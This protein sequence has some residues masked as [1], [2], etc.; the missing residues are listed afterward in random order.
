MGGEILVRRMTNAIRPG[1]AAS[2]LAKDDAQPSMPGIG[3]RPPLRGSVQKRA[4]D[5][6]WGGWRRNG[7]NGR[8]REA[9]RPVPGRVLV[10]MRAWGAEEPGR[11]TGVRVAI[12]VRKRRNGRGAKGHRKATL[13]GAGSRR[14]TAASAARL[15]GDGHHLTAEGGDWE[16]C[17]EQLPVR[18]RER[19]SYGP[20]RAPPTGEPDA[21]DPHV[22]FGGR[23][24]A[25]ASSLPRSGPNG[26]QSWPGF[27]L[28]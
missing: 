13:G 25:T 20:H 14:P 22:R 12:V 6:T 26:Q 2:L 18:P 19:S 17:T 24:D 8:A 21:G 3:K 28:Q 7:I 15:R 27:N 1:G 11:G 5:S 23:G 9:G 16:G 10:F 4:G